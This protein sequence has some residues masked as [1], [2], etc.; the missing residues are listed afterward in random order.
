L[1]ASGQISD[2]IPWG[3]LHHSLMVAHELKLA[4][5]QQGLTLADVEERT[6]IDRAQLCK[7]ES[8]QTNPTMQTIT[9]YA[10]GL[11]KRVRLVLEDLVPQEEPVN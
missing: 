2:S 9:R 11:G 4:R 6:G 8:G 7:L 5:E 3:E 1:I 10:T